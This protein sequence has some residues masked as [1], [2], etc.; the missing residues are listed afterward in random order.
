MFG[1]FLLPSLLHHDPRYFVLAPGSSVSQRITHALKRMIIAPTDGGGQAFNISGLLGPLGA[2][3]LANTYLPD[4]E[5]TAGKTFER[6]GIQLGII[7][8]SNVAKEFWP[9]IFKTL[10]M[11]KVAPGGNLNP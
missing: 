6:Y 3:G 10:R 8:S 11:G 5:R 1:T 9:L 4:A 2:Q 7:A